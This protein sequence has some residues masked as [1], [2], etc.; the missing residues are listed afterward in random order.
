M[1]NPLTR[2]TNLSR[3]QDAESATEAHTTAGVPDTRASAVV[4]PYRG[5]ETHGVAVVDLPDVDADEADYGVTV[6]VPVER[7]EPDP[8]PIPVR[9]VTSGDGDELK[10]WRVI[11]EYVRPNESRQILG[12]DELRNNTRIRNVHATDIVYLSHESF[13]DPGNGYPLAA[14][15]E[16]T[17]TRAVTP[18]WAFTNGANGIPLAISIETSIQR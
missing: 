17:L 2:P 14:G 11:R 8:D 4:L 3:R 5:T 9:V 12:Q 13:A 18:V 6:A 1:P 15:S 16:F 7:P 10:T